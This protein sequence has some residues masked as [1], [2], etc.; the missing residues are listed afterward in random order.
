MGEGE[1]VGEGVVV[2]VRE[3]FTA[4]FG[5]V[6]RSSEQGRGWWRSAA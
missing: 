5:L 6:K 2:V 3:R 4:R 1:G